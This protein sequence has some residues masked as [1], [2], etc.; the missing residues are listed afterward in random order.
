MQ[1]H[2][3]IMSPY[4]AKHSAANRVRVL[5]AKFLIP[6]ASCVRVVSERIKRS[7]NRDAIVLPIFSE[8]KTGTF[9][10]KKKYPRHNFYLLMVGRLARE[11][12][13][14]LALNAF[15]NI[16]GKNIDAILIIV[17]EG[18][19]KK[20]IEYRIKN[21]GLEDRVKLEGWQEDVG[22]YYES[23]DA[24][25][26]TSD[27][28]GYNIASVEAIASALPVIMTDVGVAGEVVKNG[29][30]GIVVPVG[31]KTLF[32]MALENFLTDS[33]LR[34]RLIEGA[35]NTK[36]PYKSFEEYRDKLILSFKQC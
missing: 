8:K 27:Y 20:N 31:N 22:G 7:I 14:F 4:F 21:Y 16:V 17:G 26:L 6:R 28:E 32:S 18:P 5:L 23:A 10:L 33:N 25:L 11:K 29:V 13:I 3:D 36:M 34:A 15:K 35:K 30:N 9:D 12:N 19:E 24:F 1:I 2:T